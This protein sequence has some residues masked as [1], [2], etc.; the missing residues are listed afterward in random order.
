MEFALNVFVHS[1]CPQERSFRAYIKRAY[2]QLVVYALHT[3][4]A[5][6][7]WAVR[8]PSELWEHILAHTTRDT[9]GRLGRLYHNV[10]RTKS[11]AMARAYSSESLEDRYGDAESM[12]DVAWLQQ[13]FGELFDTN[14]S[15]S[16]H[17][18]FQRLHTQGCLCQERLEVVYYLMRVSLRGHGKVFSECWIS[19]ISF[20][21][22]A[23]RYD[24]QDLVRFILQHRPPGDYC[25]DT[26]ERLFKIPAMESRCTAWNQ[27]MWLPYLY[28][29]HTISS[30]NF[31]RSLLPYT[32]FHLP[33]FVFCELKNRKLFA[34]ILV[35]RDA[36]QPLEIPVELWQALHEHFY[37]KSVY[38]RRFADGFAEFFKQC[39]N[40]N[41]RVRLMR[42][43]IWAGAHHFLQMD[44][45][46]NNQI[47]A[48]LPWIAV[49]DM[50]ANGLLKVLAW[51][52]KC[53]GVTPRELESKHMDLICAGIR[54]AV[55]NGH[56]HVLR[57]YRSFVTLDILESSNY[58]AIRKAAKN[59]H[60]PVLEWLRMYFGAAF[61]VG[62]FKA[63]SSYAL[64][65]C[66]T[67]ELPKQHAVVQWILQHFGHAW[68]KDELLPIMDKC[69]PTP[70]ATLF[71]HKFCEW[72]LA[73]FD[74]IA[75]HRFRRGCLASCDMIK[76]QFP[77]AYPWANFVTLM[78]RDP[79]WHQHWDD[80]QFRWVLKHCSRSMSD[81]ERRIFVAKREKTRREQ[82]DLM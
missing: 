32:T 74:N 80:A 55:I 72:K 69:V 17:D 40:D 11:F 26:N 10:R 57:E 31:L 28:E 33:A 59:G 12:S 4:E 2:G 52:C 47:A 51:F 82:A 36:M 21:P 48:N 5:P 44:T 53:K 45:N 67:S 20:L 23:F 81:A 6:R 63:C 7:E 24:D 30:A 66:V 75:M 42:R 70:F 22:A 25:Y 38:V 39:S 3:M 1:S 61:P 49:R 15:L 37:E 34:A 56:M 50:L 64:R 73:D 62:S 79:Q 19:W 14:H 58:L 43:L 71:L 65:K 35:F 27:I 60:L 41:D 18:R 77:D 78:E 76:R 54:G 8:V 29:C 13:H 68:Q 46:L 16:V 9:V